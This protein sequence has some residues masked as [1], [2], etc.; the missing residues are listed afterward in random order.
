MNVAIGTTHRTSDP[1]GIVAALCG[2]AGFATTIVLWIAQL[3]PESNFLG[4]YVAGMAARMDL[5]ED[6]IVLAGLLGLTAILAAFLSSAGG[7]ARSSCVLAIV[8]GAVALIYPVL[9]W[10]GIVGGPVTPT[11]FTGL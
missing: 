1:L 8:L 7:P 6:L 10:Q 5:R 2:A 9:A 4:E 11:S 3:H